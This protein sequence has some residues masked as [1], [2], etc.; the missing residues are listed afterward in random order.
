MLSVCCFGLGLCM[1]CFLPLCL[2][3]PPSQA[4]SY[5]PH[6]IKEATF[7]TEIKLA[8]LQVDT[9]DVK[10]TKI[11]NTEIYYSGQIGCPQKSKIQGTVI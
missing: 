3:Q 7:R 5:V 8:L 9:W 1:W 4:N 6:L 10:D 2:S 11:G